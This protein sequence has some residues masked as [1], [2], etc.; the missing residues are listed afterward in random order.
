MYW[1]LVVVVVV[2]LT[3]I[4]TAFVSRELTLRRQEELTPVPADNFLDV[5]THT[6]TADLSS[7]ALHM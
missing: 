2:K 5:D 1:L 6:H 7:A 3:I 4:R